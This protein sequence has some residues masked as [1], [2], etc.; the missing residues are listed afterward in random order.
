MSDKNSSA[1]LGPS[2]MMNI[3]QISRPGSRQHNTG[4]INI[5]DIL[6]G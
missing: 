2:N 6:K 1:T 5:N 4:A 3:V